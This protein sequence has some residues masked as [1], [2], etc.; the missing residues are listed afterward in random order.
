MPRPISLAVAFLLAVGLVSPVMADTTA[1]SIPVFPVAGAELGGIERAS[2]TLGVAYAFDVATLKGPFVA[3][4]AGY[5]ASGWVAG[6]IFMVSPH[7]GSVDV[8]LKVLNTSRHAGV[9]DVDQKIYG[10]EMGAG[11]IRL[12]L[13]RGPERP[14]GPNQTAVRFGVGL[15]L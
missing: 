1:P 14:D 8:S 3:V 5:S 7:T 9:F 11:I 12:D 2:V 4:R 6:Y 13:V 10:V 15:L